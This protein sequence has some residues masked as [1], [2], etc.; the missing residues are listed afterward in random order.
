MISN[1]AMV[2]LLV[3]WQDVEADLKDKNGGIGFEAGKALWCDIL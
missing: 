3:K 2:K 1:E